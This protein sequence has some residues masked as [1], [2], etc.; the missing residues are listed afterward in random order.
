MA[1]L[2]IHTLV[3]ITP[4]LQKGELLTNFHSYI[5]ILLQHPVL[6]GEQTFFPWRGESPVSICS[7]S[8]DIKKQKQIH[9]KLFIL[10]SSLMETSAQSSVSWVLTQNPVIYLKACFLLH[11][12]DSQIYQECW[13]P[14]VPIYEASAGGITA[15][16]VLAA[17]GTFPFYSN[18]GHIQSCPQCVIMNVFFTSLMLKLTFPLIV[19]PPL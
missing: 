5:T 4:S 6:H 3:G 16:K 10:S 15:P 18:D 11:K 1:L 2:V 19:T 9:I 7:V 14:L 8:W 17:S 13:N 12:N